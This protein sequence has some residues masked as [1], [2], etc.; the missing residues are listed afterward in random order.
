MTMTEGEIGGIACN[1][2]KRLGGTDL[3]WVG[4]PRVRDAW[5]REVAAVVRDAQSKYWDSIPPNPSVT[6]ERMMDL[7]N[8]A[9]DKDGSNITKFG[10]MLIAEDRKNLAVAARP[11]STARGCR[12]EEAGANAGA[13][14]N[15]SVS[16]A[17]GNLPDR[18]DSFADQCEPGSQHQSD[19][20]AAATCLR[21]APPRVQW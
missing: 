16:P 11:V 20:Y 1:L 14:P 12:P 13:M 19:L 9:I 21:K 18:L 7:W 2:F 6:A 4:K 10:D 3:E 5:T 8:E 15:A 17:A